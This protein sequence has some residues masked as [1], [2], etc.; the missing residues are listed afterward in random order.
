MQKSIYHWLFFVCLLFL[1]IELDAKIDSQNASSAPLANPVFA[2]D[3]RH[4]PTA[5]PLD[6]LKM[7]KKLRQF[8]EK[9]LEKRLYTEGSSKPKAKKRNPIWG[10]IF[11][12]LLLIMAGALLVYWLQGTVG[13]LIATLGIASFW[14]NRDR[15]ADWERRR[16]ERI[17]AYQSESKEA[18]ANGRGSDSLNHIS[19]RFT[20]RSI[21]RFLVGM[22]LTFLGFILALA[23]IF[24]SSTASSAIGILVVLMVLIGYIFTIVGVVNG[25]QAI[26]AKEPQSAWSWLVV[27]FGIPTILSLFAILLAIAAA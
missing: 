25:V 11:T 5:N 24:A 17:Y 18:D 13:L 26:V 3:Q 16:Q 27:I 12:A 20:R 8:I 15:I 21:T 14:R 4:F 9:R 22:G 2:E 10:R 6:R 23:T 1:S 19:N 7:P